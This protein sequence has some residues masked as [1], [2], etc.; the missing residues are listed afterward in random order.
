MSDNSWETSV[1]DLEMTAYLSG[2]NDSAPHF[3]VPLG[4]FAMDIPGKANK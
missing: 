4:M 3:T 2:E 1:R